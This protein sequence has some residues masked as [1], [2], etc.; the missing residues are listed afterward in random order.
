M[1]SF[2]LF[3]HGNYDSSSLAKQQA[4]ALKARSESLAA[5]AF[6]AEDVIL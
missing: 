5:F 1:R 6:L 2:G 3:S 4:E